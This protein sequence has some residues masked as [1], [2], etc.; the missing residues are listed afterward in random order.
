MS[1]AK[2]EV[3]RRQALMDRIDPQEDPGEPVELPAG[4]HQPKSVS[5][6]IQEQIAIEIAKKHTGS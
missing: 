2:N 1:K 6:Q 3:S 4:T 5:I